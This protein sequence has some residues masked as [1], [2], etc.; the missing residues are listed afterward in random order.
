MSA[1]L[2]VEITESRGGDVV[3]ITDID[4][5]AVL[6]FFGFVLLEAGPAKAKNRKRGKPLTEFK[7]QT[8]HPDDAYKIDDIFKEYN[9]DTLKC[10]PRK[11]LAESR[12]LRNLVHQQEVRA[13]QEK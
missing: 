10:S 9:N 5:A 12:H 1:H 2:N 6:R 7:F 4:L 11:L 13:P 8:A 3:A